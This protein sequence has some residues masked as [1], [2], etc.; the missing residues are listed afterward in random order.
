[1]ILDPH[2]PRCFGFVRA[3][4]E[5]SQTNHRSGCSWVSE[6]A[7]IEER[8]RSEGSALHH[9]HA[10]PWVGIDGRVEPSEARVV[11]VA[12][13]EQ[14]ERRGPRRAL[15][16]LLGALLRIEALEGVAQAS[17]ALWRARRTELDCADA[18]RARI[19]L[20]PL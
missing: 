3:W 15:G 8:R 1:E 18:E 9:P 17:E 11:E 20:D 7:S 14:D 4:R 16:W 13:D 12:V 19:E 2:A 10:L 5:Q 6:L